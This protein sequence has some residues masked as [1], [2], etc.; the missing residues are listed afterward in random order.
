MSHD[1]DWRRYVNNDGDFELPRYLYLV[2][3]ELMKSALDMGTLL[4]TDQSKLRAFR[5]QTKGAFKRR[6]MELAQA[7]EAFDIIAPCG[8]PLSEYCKR[9]GGSRYLLNTALSPDEMREI[10]MVTA[11]GANGEIEKKLQLGLAKAL[12][13]VRDG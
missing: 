11:P 9:C 7:L 1:V 3:N 4:S 5:D 10:A 8:C 12:V 6:W 13:E 2:L